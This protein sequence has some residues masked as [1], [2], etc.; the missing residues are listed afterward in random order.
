MLHACVQRFDVTGDRGNILRNERGLRKF[1]VNRHDKMH[2]AIHTCT[3][4]PVEF[5]RYSVSWL[6]HAQ[7]LGIYN[8]HGEK[9]N[10]E[11]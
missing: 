10:M 7:L 5:H 8:E 11:I 4:S 1:T 9:A 2:A 6:A 3:T